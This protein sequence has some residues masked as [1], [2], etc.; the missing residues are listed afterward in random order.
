[1]FVKGKATTNNAFSNSYKHNIT[2]EE[3]KHE[4]KHKTRTEVYL[5][6]WAWRKTTRLDLIDLKINN[7]LEDTSDELAV[8]PMEGIEIYA[9]ADADRLL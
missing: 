6:H 7:L 3:N 4:V 2:N 8:E 1:M 5:L 9:D